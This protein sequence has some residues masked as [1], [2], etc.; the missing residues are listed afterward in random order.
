LQIVESVMLWP[1]DPEMQRHAIS[2]AVVTEGLANFHDLS[3]IELANLLHLSARSLP[4]EHIQQQIEKPF[5]R[6]VVSGHI[7]RLALLENA[8]NSRSNALGEAKKTASK[9]FSAA[10]RLSVS[11]IENQ[12]WKF[13]RPVAHYW[14]AFLS[15]DDRRAFPCR[16]DTFVELLSKAEA[17][18][19]AGEGAQVYKSGTILDSRESVN[20]P[21]S[22]TV[23]VANLV[24]SVA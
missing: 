9:M 5:V 14:A 18:R 7:L 21:R 10:R 11:T 15:L 19:K 17:F 1:G 8:K 24:L 13:Y 4:L 20:L 16:T 22:V 12:V 6:G 23:P 3:E 2:A